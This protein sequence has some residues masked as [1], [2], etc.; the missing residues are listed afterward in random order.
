MSEME[1]GTNWPITGECKWEWILF[2][3]LFIVV[4]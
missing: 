4:L 3:T 2:N 1:M